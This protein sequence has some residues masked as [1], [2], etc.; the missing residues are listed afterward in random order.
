MDKAQELAVL[1]S[2]GMLFTFFL[3]FGIILLAKK[4]REIQ[5]LSDRLINEEKA[6]KEIEKL[7][8][9]LETQET[10]RSQIA[11]MLHDEVG[12]ILSIAQK[13][14]LIIQKQAKIGVF[15]H[16]SIEMTR[17]FIQE[18][19]N[20][21]RQINKG[22]IP[23]YLLKFGLVKA[24]ERMGKQKTDGLIDSYVF[25]AQIAQNL[26]ISDQVMT[27]YFYIASE[28]ITN[29]LKH[30]FPTSINMKLYVEGNQLK[31]QLKHDGIA[32]SQRDYIALSKESENLGLENIRYRL[33]MIN[34]E[35]LFNRTKTSGIIEIIT[36]L[37]N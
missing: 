24:L 37:N 2:S 25:N 32:L 18:S 30:S 15:E 17:D 13:N 21:L 29:L 6:N 33:S 36:N 7:Q 10:E 8:V 27:Q 4:N 23:H 19:I 11:R 35:I 14:I 9:A 16:K 1:I 28:L 12:A 5:E 22:L 31:L 3:G 26:V 20:Q 34:G